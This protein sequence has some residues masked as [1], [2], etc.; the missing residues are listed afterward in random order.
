MDV[1]A[2]R[3]AS[4]GGSVDEPRAVSR[5]PRR[6]LILALGCAGFLVGLVAIVAPY[7]SWY[8]GPI[9]PW[10]IATEVA[11]G[12]SFVFLGLYIRWRRPENRIGMLSVAAGFAWFTYVIGWIPTDLTWTLGWL[13]G[14]LYLALLAH[15]FLAFPSGRLES[16]GD[17]ALVIVLYLSLVVSTFA[18]A[19]F[20]DPGGGPFRNVLVVLPNN[21]VADAIGRVNA[22]VAAVLA[23]SAAVALAVHW[24][25]G[26]PALRRSIQPV[27]VAGIPMIAWALFL[28]VGDVLGIHKD[29]TTPFF[30]NAGM[31]AQVALP[32]GFAVGLLRTRLARSSVGELVVELGS[33]ELPRSGLRDALAHRLGDPTL[34]IAYFVPEP[35]EYVDASGRPVT[36]PPEDSGRSVTTL[37]RDGEPIAA[38]IH[39]EV[40]RHDPELVEAV[41]AA[42]RLAIWNE[43]LQ[44][45]VRAKLE[46]V[47][48]SRA[49]IVE[50][51]DAERRRVERNLHDGA[52][53]RLVSLSLALA[54]I[55]E[56]IGPNDDGSLADAVDAAAGELKAAIAELR[57]LARGI[58]PAVLTQQGLGA[59]VAALAERAPI[60]VGVDDHSRTRGSE[61][62]E[63]TAYFVVA[64]ALTNIAKH[65]DA[66]HADVLIEQRGEILRVEI[67]DDGV[68]GADASK[69]SGLRGMEDRVAA[70]GGTFTVSSQM[71]AGSTV[72]AAI[73]LGER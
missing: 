31:L 55:R 19:I 33:T 70:L 11:V 16:A 22:G 51:G 68:G 15:L 8:E 46:D 14:G 62:A 66:T 36:L 49:R 18:H 54:M 69:G 6:V 35:A 21:S 4:M 32:V 5:R 61:P 3:A 39:D 45:E 57:E 24:I 7:V 34:E 17:R 40:L 2:I 25:R 37:E 67:S 20:W 71:G 30:G 65:A 63:A 42:A 47:R 43:R 50:A 13:L 23:M 10:R 9:D 58:H 72:R 41:A 52:Q 28:F 73:P 48:A 27:I 60:P 56:Q 26:T 64:E 38:L 12:W 29:S 1:T 53:Q 59:A 44:A